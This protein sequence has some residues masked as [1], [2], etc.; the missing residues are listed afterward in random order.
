MQEN[1]FRFR[2][3]AFMARE[4]AMMKSKLTIGSWEQGQKEHGGEH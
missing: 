4:F 1:A 3:L 2:L